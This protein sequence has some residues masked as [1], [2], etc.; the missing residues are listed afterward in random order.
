MVVHSRSRKTVISLEINC[1]HVQCAERDSISHQP[2]GDTPTL[3][4]MKDFTHVLFVD[5]ISAIFKT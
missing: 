2:L 3:T 5:K 1:T 4:Q